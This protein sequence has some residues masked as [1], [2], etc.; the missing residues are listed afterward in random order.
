MHRPDITTLTQLAINHWQT[1]LP[2]MANS[3]K[4]VGDL[5]AQALRAAHQTLS[6]WA[7]LTASQLTPEAAWEIVR[8][9]YILLPPETPPTPAT[10]DLTPIYQ[11]LAQLQRA[12]EDF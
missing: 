5:H 3:L 4:R 1:H 6:E 11:E 8:E 10:S 9:R 7:S 12:L 2:E